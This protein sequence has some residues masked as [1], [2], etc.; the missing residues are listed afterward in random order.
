MIVQAFNGFSLMKNLNPSGDQP[1]ASPKVLL[2]FLS[3]NALT[4][5]TLPKVIHTSKTHPSLSHNPIITIPYLPS[6]HSPTFPLSHRT[7]FLLLFAHH[8]F[9]L[10]HNQYKSSYISPITYCPIHTIMAYHQKIQTQESLQD[11]ERIQAAQAEAY[12]FSMAFVW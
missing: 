2:L 12:D 7:I 6:S 4:S 1:K 3:Q 11:I 10:L 9:P 5:C 8:T